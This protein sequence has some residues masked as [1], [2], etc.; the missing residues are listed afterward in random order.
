[1]ELP[2]FIEPTT[3]DSY[4]KQGEPIGEGTYGTV[5]KAT[6]KFN[7]SALAMKKVVL[8]SEREGFP[9]TAIREVRALKKLD[10]HPNIVKLVDVCAA[11]PA[12]A[13]NGAGD[14]YLIFEYQPSDLTG[15]IAY[16]KNRFK[17]PEVKCLMHQLMNALDYCHLNGVMHR[18][19]KPSNIL[20]G[21]DGN[22]T[23]CDFGLSRNYQ[24]EGNYSV[25]VITLWYRPAELL[26]GTKRYDQ[27]VDIWSAGCIFGELILGSPLFPD[28]TELGVFRKICERLPPPAAWPEALRTLPLWE[29]MLPQAR[30]PD[31]QASSHVFNELASKTGT[32]GLAIFK[33][34]LALDPAER[35]SADWVLKQPYWHQEPAMC[36]KKEVKVAQ[37]LAIHEL[38]VKRHREKQ[39]AE[40]EAS[41]NAMSSQRRAAVPAVRAAASPGAQAVSQPL[42]MLQHQ[43]QARRVG[44]QAHNGSAA[45]PS[46]GLGRALGDAA[47]PSP[48]RARIRR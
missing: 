39:R 8:R 26:L 16:R 5:W 15:L 2:D 3:A 25:R 10:T 47:A 34:M 32:Q 27:R 46:G 23:L 38:E 12:S 22:L 17:V 31:E 21:N 33:A 30:R 29:K 40:R 13:T 44:T 7:D 45:P 19:L 41:R 9:M 1:M 37:F 4:E 48:K 24:G 35:C 20:V 28:S 43:G 11:P 42:G 18:D 36:D 6:S 14:A